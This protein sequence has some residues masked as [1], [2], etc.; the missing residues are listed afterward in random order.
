MDA[1]ITKT[2]SASKPSHLYVPLYVKHFY[3]CKKNRL[4]MNLTKKNGIISWYFFSI[5]LGCSVLGTERGSEIKNQCWR[6]LIWKILQTATWSH[7]RVGWLS[8]IRCGV[9]RNLHKRRRDSGIL[10]GKFNCLTV[11]KLWVSLYDIMTQATDTIRYEPVK[12][13]RKERKT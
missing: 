8:S 13:E 6:S 9:G 11:S 1:Y 12:Y 5:G 4:V 2:V 10:R 3:T 7:K